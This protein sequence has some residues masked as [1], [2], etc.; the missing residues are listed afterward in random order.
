[1]EL[2]LDT[3]VMLGLAEPEVYPLPKRI[4]YALEESPLNFFVSSASLW[5]LAIKHRLGKLPLLVP[6]SEWPTLLFV[7][8]LHLI[9]INVSHILA[10]LDPGPD[11]K[12]PFDR[13]ILATAAV[14]R[15]QLATIDGELIDHPLA[16]RP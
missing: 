15:M 2:L 10:D 16:W 14:E 9:D 6:L 1:M 13:L 7:T 3:H 11:T 5:E 12:D 8:G 4:A